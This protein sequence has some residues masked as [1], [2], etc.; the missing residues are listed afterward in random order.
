MSGK[1]TSKGLTSLKWN[2]RPEGSVLTLMHVSIPVLLCNMITSAPGRS[3]WK[4]HII[5]TGDANLI[6]AETQ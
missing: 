6:Q 2:P 4:T 3:D 1:I 5:Y